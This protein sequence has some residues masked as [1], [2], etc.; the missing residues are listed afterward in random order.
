KPPRDHILP[1]LATRTEPLLQYLP[2]G[3]QD[4]HGHS[5]RNLLLQLSR[6]L[7]IDVEYQIQAPSPG[8]LEAVPVSAV[9]VAKYLSPFKEFVAGKPGFKVFPADEAVAQALRLGAARLARGVRN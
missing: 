5:F 8:L 7:D 2:R 3:G 4:K 1:V 9:I 6:T